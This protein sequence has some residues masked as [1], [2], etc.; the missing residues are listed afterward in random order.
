MREEVTDGEG[1]LSE[2]GREFENVSG[3]LAE[4]ARR[5]EIVGQVRE[6]FEFPVE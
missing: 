4:Q 1:N 3:N 5:L 6:S 2:C